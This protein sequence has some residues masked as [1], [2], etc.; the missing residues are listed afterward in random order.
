MVAGIPKS[1]LSISALDILLGKYRIAGRSSGVPQRMPE[2]I[3]FSHDHGVK[4]HVT[5]CN[6]ILDIN[7]MIETMEA[8]KAAGRLGIVFE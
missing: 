4:S 6:N 8:G 5:V 3:Q 2:A 1:E 7:K